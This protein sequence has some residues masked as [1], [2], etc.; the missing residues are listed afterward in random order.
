MRDDVNG[1]IVLPPGA[2]FWP[3]LSNAALAMTA[4]ITVDVIQTPFN[5]ATM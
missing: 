3:Y 2:S 1:M 4:L 5:S